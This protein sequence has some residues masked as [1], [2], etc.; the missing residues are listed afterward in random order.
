M[1]SSALS[2]QRR[3]Q[4]GSVQR[5]LR[6]LHKPLRQRQSA[7]A[8]RS[9]ACRC[10]CGSDL[11]CLPTCSADR[12][13]L[14]SKHYSSSTVR[15]TQARLGRGEF[16]PETTR[17]LHYVRNPEAETQR[18]LAETHIAELDAENKVQT[19]HSNVPLPSMVRTSPCAAIMLLAVPCPNSHGCAD[20]GAANSAAAAGGAAT[21]AF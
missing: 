19:S 6:R 20:A 18:Q 12:F 11:L 1:R 9:R 21:A 4:S 3:Q 16:N 8:S 2:R 7:S 14:L 15:C 13:A 5:L 10:G 17:I